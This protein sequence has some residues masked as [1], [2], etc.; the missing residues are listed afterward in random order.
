MFGT[1]FVEK[2]IIMQFLGMEKDK[3][4]G[5]QRRDAEA[6]RKDLRK[7]RDEKII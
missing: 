1:D 4:K 3:K 5:S 7:I 6:L 2:C